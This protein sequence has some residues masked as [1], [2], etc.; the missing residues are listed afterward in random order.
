MSKYR[1]VGSASSMD[2]L[3]K[4]I[5]VKLYCTVV[6]TPVESY[7]WSVINKNGPM[8]GWRIR[9]VGRRYRLEVQHE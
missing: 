5:E 3:I 2:Q 9:L 6:A 8:D 7:G 1:L 4:L